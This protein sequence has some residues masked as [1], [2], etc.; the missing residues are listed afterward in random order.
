MTKQ[1]LIELGYD[2]TKVYNIGG[3][4]AYNGKHRIEM[5]TY[6]DGKQTGAYEES[7]YS[8]YNANYMDIRTTLDYLTKKEA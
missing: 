8:F 3:F 6:Y 7:F 5:V 4:W 2:E 1:I